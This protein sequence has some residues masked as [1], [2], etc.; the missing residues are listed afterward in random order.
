MAKR[1]YVSSI[2]QQI[3]E[4][5][6]EIERLENEYGE[7]LIAS[8]SDDDILVRSMFPAKIIARG[9]DL[10]SGREYVW[11]GAGTEVK[12]DRRDVDVLLKKRRGGS[13]CCGG[14]GSYALFE[15]V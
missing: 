2:D 3:D 12:V 6:D 14:D 9:G 13:G 8:V 7:T 11:E 15:L 4:E 5:L 10:P 1:S